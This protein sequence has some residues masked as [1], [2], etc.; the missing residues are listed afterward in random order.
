MIDIHLRETIETLRRRKTASL[1]LVRKA[2]HGLRHPNGRLGVFPASFNPP[3]KA[4][5]ALIREA[6]RRFKLDEVL[7]LLDLQ[8]MDKVM[9]GASFED[10]LRMLEVLFERHSTISIGLSNRGLFT[11][12][13]EPLRR[14]YPSPIRFVF[15]VGFDTILRVMDKKYYRN[16]KRS[17]NHLFG[18]CEFLVA[19]RGD[20]EKEAFERIFLQRGNDRYKERIH[21]LPLSRNLSCISSSLVREKLGGGKSFKHLVPLPVFRFIKETEL[22]SRR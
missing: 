16:R 17:L 19:N 1:R 10:R 11:E 9:I 18:E 2:P 14:F 3:T 20:H 15:M 13:L 12:K 8:A 4:H 21:F 22:Y 5:V 6:T 7:V